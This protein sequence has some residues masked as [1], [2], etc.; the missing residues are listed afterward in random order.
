MKII[1]KFAPKLNYSMKGQ[2]KGFDSAY[3][4]KKQEKKKQ[5]K[6]KNEEL[7]GKK[8]YDLYRHSTKLIE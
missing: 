2:D 3:Y 1:L 7:D 8:L 6:S 5:K 4:Q